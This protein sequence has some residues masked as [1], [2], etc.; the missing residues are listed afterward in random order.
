MLLLFNP[1]AAF[2]SQ[3]VSSAAVLFVVSLFYGY[4]AQLIRVQKALKEEAEQKTRER[5]KCL[6]LSPTNFDTLKLD[7]RLRAGPEERHFGRGYGRAKAG[8]SQDHTTI[9]QLAVPGHTILDLTRIAGDLSV[10][11]ERFRLPNIFGR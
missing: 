1:P 11:R 6:I 5:K 8:V 9:R 3:C 7:Q 2:S 10:Q 4:F